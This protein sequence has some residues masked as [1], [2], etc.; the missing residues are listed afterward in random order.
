MTTST[1]DLVRTEYRGEVAWLTIN[2][3]KNSTRCRSSDAG[4]SQ[5]L[6]AAEA[7][8]A[9]KVV[10]LQG[11][12]KRSASATTSLRKSRSS[13]DRR[14]WHALPTISGCRCRCGG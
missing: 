8:P 4:L 11:G 7:D 6:T 3:P 9:I 1:D 12:E 2:R 10:V 14:Q 5:A 13:L